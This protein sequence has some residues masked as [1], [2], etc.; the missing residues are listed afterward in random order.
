MKNV[1]TF[2]WL[3]V[4]TDV[5]FAQ[6]CNV[7]WAMHVPGIDYRTI[8]CAGSNG[9]VHVVYRATARTI[10]QTH[11]A[12]FAMNAN[13]FDRRG[14]PIVRDGDVVPPPRSSWQSIFLAGGDGTPR[15]VMPSQWSAYRDNA[16]AAV[17]AGRAS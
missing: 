12:S 3:A 4:I 7:D 6:R 10:A 16:Q 14:D 13:F 8:E 15:I 5:A 9:G 17:Q 11:H 1:L 2:V